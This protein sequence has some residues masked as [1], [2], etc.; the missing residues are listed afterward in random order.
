MSVEALS[1]LGY[2]A[3]RSGADLASLEKGTRCMQRS[4]YDME[5]GLSTAVDAF[6]DMNL[7]IRDL[8][9]LSPEEQ[10]TLIADRLGQVEDASR[11]AAIAQQIFGRAGTMLLPMFE[12]G[13]KSMSALRAET[14]RI[15]LIGAGR[16]HAAYGAVMPRSLRYSFQAAM[17]R[18]NPAGSLLSG[19]S[20]PSG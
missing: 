3:D 13:A 7:S 6:G 16:G 10:F 14:R 18:S 12:D 5:R 9:G 4:I 8:R 17:A 2:A 15:G 20:G 11:K 19:S 1:E